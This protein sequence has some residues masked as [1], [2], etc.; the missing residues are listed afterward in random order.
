MKISIYLLSFEIFPRSENWPD[1]VTRDNGIQTVLVTGT[2]P[3]LV[4]LMFACFLKGT[5]ELL[6]NEKSSVFKMGCY[7]MEF[8]K[9]WRHLNQNSSLYKLYFNVEYHLMSSWVF[10]SFS[11]LCVLECSQKE[12]HE[13]LNSLEGEMTV[14]VQYWWQRTMLWKIGEVGDAYVGILLSHL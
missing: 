13:K 5:M 14:T 1:R 6:E 2:T 10:Q 11:Y 3:G 4:L 12:K 8:F 9:I 7:H